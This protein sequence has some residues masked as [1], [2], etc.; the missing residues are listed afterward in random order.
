MR[1]RTPLFN[2]TYSYIFFRVGL[3]GGSYLAPHVS[4]LA[5]H[6]AAQ[7]TSDPR[8]SLEMHRCGGHGVHPISIKSTCSNKR[9][10]EQDQRPYLMTRGGLG[11][12]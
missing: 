2:F 6:V 3:C 7:R 1:Y 12:V 10:S 8:A 4:Y 11:I 5:G 9:V